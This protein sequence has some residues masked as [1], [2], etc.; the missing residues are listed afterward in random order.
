M[1]A[2]EYI[3]TQNLDE[4]I[5]IRKKPIEQYLVVD[6]SLYSRQEHGYNGLRSFAIHLD[7]LIEASFGTNPDL[8]E[9][10]ECAKPD[11]VKAIEFLID[12]AS[13]PDCCTIVPSVHNQAIYVLTALGVLECVD[14][15]HVLTKPKGLDLDDV[16]WALEM[17]AEYYEHELAE[18]ADAMCEG[19]FVI[20]RDLLNQREQSLMNASPKLCPNE[21]K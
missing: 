12:R 21:D 1:N 13:G 4:R 3:K 9:Y 5:D 10:A 17:V 15:Y 7:K 8:R 20:L 18:I 19:Q 11:V 2:I 6:L 16:T 14:G